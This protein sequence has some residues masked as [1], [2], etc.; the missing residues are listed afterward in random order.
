MY[1]RAG[2]GRDERHDPL[3]DLTPALTQAQ[4]PLSML[5]ESVVHPAATF[6]PHPLA[7]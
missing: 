4:C 5:K 2:H 3:A 6:H 7:T 1:A